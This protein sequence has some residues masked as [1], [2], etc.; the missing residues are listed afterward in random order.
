[1][2]SNSIN[3][4]KCNGCQHQE[5]NEN[6]CYMFKNAPAV[7]PCAQHDKYAEVRKA[8][9]RLIRKNPL[10]LMA[11]IE[12]LKDINEPKSDKSYLN[13]LEKQVKHFERKKIA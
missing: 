8:I 9:G 12:E 1:M 3:E 7:L 6:W 2:K 11:M 5:Q 10:V 13:I 4:M